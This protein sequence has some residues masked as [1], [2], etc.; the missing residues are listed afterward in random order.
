MLE[1]KH[2]DLR[3]AVFI[4]LVSSRTMIGGCQS[5]AAQPPYSTLCLYSLSLSLKFSLSILR[6]ARLDTL[7]GLSSHLHLKPLKPSFGDDTCLYFH[8]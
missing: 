7:K 3:S 6:I 8:L 1:I 5:L 4:G 2:L